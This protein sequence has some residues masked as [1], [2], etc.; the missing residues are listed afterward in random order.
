MSRLR[1]SLEAEPA[2]MARAL[3]PLGLLGAGALFHDI[4]GVVLLL[5]ATGTV[6]AIRRDAPVRWAWAAALPIALSL[7]WGLFAPPALAIDGSDCANPLSPVATW[8]ALEAFV[9][10]GVLTTVA[11]ALKATASSLSLRWPARWVVRLAVIGFLLAGPVALLVGP[12]LARPFFGDVGYDV[13][14]LGAV[15]PALLF[16]VSNGVMEEVAYRGALLGWTARVV[17]VW[18]AVIGQAVVFGLAHSG[19]D[20]AGSPIPLMVIMGIGGLVAGAIT[21]RTRS[22]LLP[23]A[24]HIGLDIPIFYALACGS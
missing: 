4:R 7:T 3:V 18:P 22:L 24:I 15:A 23:I 13:T 21:V 17:G 20:V 8:R 11:I 16:A 19:P 12:I 5:I 9:V 2:D 6:I 14:I 1:R 10:L